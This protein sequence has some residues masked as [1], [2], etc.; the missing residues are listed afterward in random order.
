M[1]RVGVAVACLLLYTLSLQATELITA[2]CT[3]RESTQRHSNTTTHNTTTQQHNNT[4][5]Q[6]HNN[7]TTQQH[8][9]TTQQHNNIT[10]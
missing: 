2:M 8:N 1:K 7:T 10:T 5:T 4:T 3:I 9:T 6:Q